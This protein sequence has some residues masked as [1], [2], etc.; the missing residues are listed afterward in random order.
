MSQIEPNI[1]DPTKSPTPPDSVPNIDPPFPEDDQTSPDDIR[2]PGEGNAPI[3]KDPEEGGG[4]GS[5]ERAGAR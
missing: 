2:E 1:I 4:G 5:I 3:E